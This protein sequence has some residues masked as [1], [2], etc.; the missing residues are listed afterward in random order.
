MNMAL[1][2]EILGGITRA[3]FTLL[4]E[5]VSWNLA[6]NTKVSLDELK[7]ALQVAG[8][9]HD[10]AKELKNRYAFARAAKQMA[11]NRIIRCTKDEPHLMLFQFTQEALDEAAGRFTYNF[12]TTLQLDKDTGSITSEDPNAGQLV[13][14]A[15]ELLAKA[16]VERLTNDIT[17]L[18]MRLFDKQADL[19]PLRNAGGVYFVPERHM[20]FVD[21]IEKF[22]TGLGGNITRL[23]IPAGTKNGDKAVKE[24]VTSGIQ[25]LINEHLAAVEEFGNDTRPSTLSKAQAKVEATAF[26]IEAYA[27]LMEDSKER[28][29]QSLNAARLQLRQKTAEIMSYRAQAKQ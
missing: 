7:Q 23:P 2:D 27:S 20:N 22:V 5:A 3:N 8:L 4:G 24:A 15:S 11:E 1:R 28:L 26:K 10:I 14:L 21:S 12:E 19:F 18:I 16:K 13:Q 25:A 29:D 9:D 17:Q 6:E